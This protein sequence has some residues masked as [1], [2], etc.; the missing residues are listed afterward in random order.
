M[1]RVIRVYED[2]QRDRFSMRNWRY[3]NKKISNQYSIL[4][5]MTINFIFLKTL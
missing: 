3:D 2:D 4:Q 1:G 5:Y